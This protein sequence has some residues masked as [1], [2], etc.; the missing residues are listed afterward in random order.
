MPVSQ[1]SRRNAAPLPE[2]ASARGD[3]SRALGGWLSG[4]GTLADGT[5]PGTARLGLPTRGPGSV[6][7]IGRRLAGI[8]IDLFAAYLI[9]RALVLPVHHPTI[10]EITGAE[11]AAFVLQVWLLQASTGQSIGQRFTKTR[12]VGLDGGRPSPKW[13]LLR[14]ILLIFPPFVLGLIV[15]ADGRGLQDK[16]SGTVV[17]SL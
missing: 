10:N 6:A 14:V 5:V 1:K 7:S 3:A 9:G 12:I 8:V 15:D 4:P 13:L 2:A 16:A 11:T 17:L